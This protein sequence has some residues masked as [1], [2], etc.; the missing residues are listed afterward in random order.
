[1]AEERVDFESQPARSG[2]VSRR[3]VLKRGGQALLAMAAVPTVGAL[4][5]SC[6]SASAK[7]NWDELSRRLRGPLLRQGGA[8]FQAA[9]AAENARYANVV[10]AAIAMCAGAQD[11]QTSVTWARDNGVPLVARSGGHSYAGYSTTTGLQVDLNHMKSTTV[12]ASSGTLHVTGAARFEDLD[13]ALKPYNMFIPAGQCPS[14]SINGFTL[15]GGFGFYSRAHGLAVDHLVATD[16]VLASGEVVS[17]GAHQHQ[18]L[19]WACRG[20]GGGNFGINTSMTFSLY[21][22]SGVSVCTC[23]WSSNVEAVLAEFQK[24]FVSAPTAFSLIVRITPS[25]ATS[26]GGPT[27]TALGHYFGPSAELTAILDPVLTAVPSSTRQFLDLDF[28]A[29][30]NYLAEQPGPPQS[31]VERSRY[32]DGP[33]SDAGLETV[34]KWSNRWPG[35][36]ASQEGRLDFFLWGGAM[37][38]VPQDAT[39][40][41]HRRATSLFTLSASWDPNTPSQQSQPLIGWVN[42]IWEATGAYA[43]ASAYQNFTDPALQDW[44]RA[45][46]GTNLPRLTRVKRAYDPDNVFHFA[47]SIP[48]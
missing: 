30:R 31:Y 46:Y 6:S 41:V 4:A 29:A 32:V 18:D 16:V 44:Q 39:A 1:M 13:A 12:D 25:S 38:A 26:A 11:V 28:W 37:D 42:N 15:G 9:S 40:F 17:A 45:Y 19:F 47:Q 14:V 34:V 5:G 36:V 10:P 35:T 20:G 43:T 48:T 33:M 24:I 2:T 21:P 27:V 3:Q 7:P 8:G 23:E 22:V